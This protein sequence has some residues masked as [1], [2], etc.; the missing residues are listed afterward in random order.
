MPTAFV[1]MPF[2]PDLESVYTDLIKPVLTER[3]FEVFRADE[4]YNQQSILKDIIQSIDRSDLVIADLTDN[5]VNVFYELG[6]AHT[7]GKP[8]ILA[9]QSLEKVPFDLKP[10]R[11]WIYSIHFARFQK[12]K[13]ELDDLAKGFL[14]GRVAFGNPVSDILDISATRAHDNVVEELNAPAQEQS[15]DLEAVQLQQNR[16]APVSD[17]DDRGLLDHI[18]A[19]NGGYTDLAQALVKVT[20]PMMEMTD[21]MNKGTADLNRIAQDPNARSWPQITDV[22]RSIGSRIDTFADDLVSANDVFAHVMDETQDSLE[23]LVSTLVSSNKPLSTETADRIAELEKMHSQAMTAR[24]PLLS[25]ATLM[26]AVPR[27]ERGMNRGLD[28]GGSELRAFTSNLD[29]LIGSVTRALNA[30]KGHTRGQGSADGLG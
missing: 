13:Q 2:H 27:L 24:G 12:A 18:E 17:T 9:A 21:D 4:I 11:I 29:R 15:S 20:G 23:I 16:R 3:G 5:N 19:I 22:C 14:E 1:I 26:D 7:L 25:M 28:R 8:V 30:A 6:I 10:Y